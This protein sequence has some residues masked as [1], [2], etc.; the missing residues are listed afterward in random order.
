MKGLIRIKKAAAVFLAMALVFAMP[1][2]AS[3][4]AK[5]DA[6]G[7]IVEENQPLEGGIITLDI[8][9][10]FDFD[11]DAGFGMPAAQSFMSVQ[12]TVA[13]SL[14]EGHIAIESEDGAVNVAVQEDYTFL[15]HGMPE[16]GQQVIVFY[17]AGLPRPAIY[18]MLVS[19]VAVV[20][21]DEI[22]EEPLFFALGRFGL[23]HVSA[24]GAYRIIFG[25]ST[26]IF[27]QNGESMS[28]RPA[29]DEG[30]D[31]ETVPVGEDGD[32]PAVRDIL[33]HEDESPVDTPRIMLVEYSVSHRDFMPTT[34]L[35]ERV[36][37]LWEPIAAF[38]GE[39]VRLPAELDGPERNHP[40]FGSFAGTLVPDEREG[41]VGIEDE[42]GERINFGIVTGLTLGYD[43]LDEYMGEQ[44][45]GFYDMGLPAPMI[46]PP[47]HQAA[48]IVPQSEQFQIV[49]RFGA[50]LVSLC[51]T[52][53][54]AIDD[55]TRIFLQDGQTIEYVDGALL[56]AGEYPVDTARNMLVAYSVSNR[57]INPTTIR[58]L[59]IIVLWEPAAHFPLLTID[60]E[61]IVPMPLP[62]VPVETQGEE[63]PAAGA[64]AHTGEAAGGA[65]GVAVSVGDG[66]RDGYVP[67]ALVMGFLGEDVAWHGRDWKVS[68]DSPNP[69]AQGRIV[70][71]INGS[72]FTRDG[73]ESSLSRPP[74]VINGTTYVHI[75]FFREAVG[76]DN[77]D[78]IEGVARIG[79]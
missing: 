33:F 35:A 16:I 18:P 57:D 61:E 55:D 29:G 41:F 27:L 58:P 62:T 5:I 13:E 25:E 20:I 4:D 54:L 66:P 2:P 21:V 30:D 74:V 76:F 50:D 78:V 75:S 36:T 24:D 26:E 47:Q 38:D 22:G 3:A 8:Q 34:L 46:F 14:L 51:N 17:D 12:G 49:A 68:F 28:R 48:A 59:E 10:D 1:L 15:R 43:A 7:N 19:A 9:L 11:G 73:E 44:V 70:V 67:L 52:Y 37:V 63:I 79:N 39:A 65:S 60:G 72:S 6:D 42:D 31:A 40:G 77:A 69:D 56:I 64:R 23:D 45:I 53:R 32:E 71:S